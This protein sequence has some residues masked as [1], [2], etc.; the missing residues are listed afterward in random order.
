MIIDQPIDMM[1]DLKNFD[2][3]VERMK[4]YCEQESIMRIIN[5]PTQMPP[6]SAHIREP[7]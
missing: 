3:S 1:L 5:I 7:W 2:C 6:E 4:K